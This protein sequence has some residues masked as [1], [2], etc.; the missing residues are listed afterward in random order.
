MISLELATAISAA[1]AALGDD[2]ADL[3]RRDALNDLAGRAA[4]GDAEAL[5]GVLTMLTEQVAEL[6]SELRCKRV[7]QLAMYAL[8]ASGA[9][10]S[11][12]GPAPLGSVARAWP[13]LVPRSA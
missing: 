13:S 8:C 3:A 1:L 2:P 6:Q 7:T 4:G 10:R 5:A 11:D 12:E 9:G